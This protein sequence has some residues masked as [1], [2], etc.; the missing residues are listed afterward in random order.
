VIGLRSEWSG[1]SGQAS[2]LELTVPH[3]KSWVEG[4]WNVAD[5]DRRIM[6]L[7]LDLNLKLEGSPTLVDFGAG[8]TVYGQIK[9]RQR[10]ELE[11]GRSQD[12][13]EGW[14][15][16]QGEGANLAIFAASTPRI[17]RLAEGWAHVMDARRCTA[18]ALADF[19]KGGNLDRI[20][21]EADGHL[22]LTR[23]FPETAGEPKIFHFWLHFVPMPVQVGAATSPQAILEPPRVEWDR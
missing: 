7:A 6:S 19:G 16:R 22:R 15:I 11:A 12:R 9:G 13:A 2:T 17:P 8:S 1:P 14:V 18:L 4:A 23:Q 3:S 10:M 20:S 5:P 21:V